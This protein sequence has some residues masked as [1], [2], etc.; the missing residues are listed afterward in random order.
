[1]SLDLLL[2]EAV[3]SF[4]ENPVRDETNLI[5]ILMPESNSVSFLMSEQRYAL[6][7]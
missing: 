3:G 7:M 4:I 6:L 2:S 1:M 5:K